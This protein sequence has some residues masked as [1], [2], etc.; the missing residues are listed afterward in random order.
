MKSVIDSINH[1]TCRDVLDNFYFYKNQPIESPHQ[2]FTCPCQRIAIIRSLAR[3]ATNNADLF[4][5]DPFVVAGGKGQQPEEILL[6]HLH[7]YVYLECS[8]YLVDMECIGPWC[9]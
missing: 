3:F 2:F 7:H 8:H 1:S 4:C 6:A 9:H 5:M